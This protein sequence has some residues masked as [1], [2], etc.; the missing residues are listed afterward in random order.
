VP[1]SSGSKNDHLDYLNMSLQNNGNCK[2]SETYTVL[3]SMGINSSAASL[4]K[5]R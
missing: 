2:Y 1:S 5:P 4:R 3:S